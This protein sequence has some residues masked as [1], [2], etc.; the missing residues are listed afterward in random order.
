M[1][2]EGE[3]RRGLAV[4][5]LAELLEPPE[6]W[7]DRG[8]RAWWERAR[9]IALDRAQTKGVCECGR[10]RRLEIVRGLMNNHGRVVPIA[11]A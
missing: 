4:S 10:N 6:A 5:A 3:E 8:V 2:R 1:G 7:P 9:P 11:V